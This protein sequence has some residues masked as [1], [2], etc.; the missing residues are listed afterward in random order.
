MQGRLGL[1]RDSLQLW[2]EFTQTPHDA[3]ECSGRAQ[4]GYEMRHLAGRLL[5][6]L[7][8]GRFVMSTP[9]SVVVV[10]IGIEI[11][12]GMRGVKLARDL[13]S[14]VGREH[15]ICFDDFDVVIA[16]DPFALIAGV[17]RQAHFYRIPVC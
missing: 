17:L 2:I 10:L 7:I 12:P 15:W 16:Q 6:D 11:L 5:P 13:L 8:G 3:D 9:V 14:A 1:D 4:P